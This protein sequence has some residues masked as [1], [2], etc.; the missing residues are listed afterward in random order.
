MGG[1]EL[2]RQPQA[3]DPGHVLRARP[4]PKLLAGAMDDR[5]DR[6]P[7]AHD[8]GADPLGSADLVAGDGDESTADVPE[9][10]RDLADR[11]NGVR[12]EGDVRLS[13]STR[14]PPQRLHRPDLVVYPHAPAD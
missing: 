11:L 4:Q 1:G 9:R 13:T 5:L 10:D 7:V 12:M 6:V 3:D 8:Q 14:E 2:H